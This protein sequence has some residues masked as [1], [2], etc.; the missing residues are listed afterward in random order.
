MKNCYKCKRLQ[1]NKNFYKHFKNK[2]GL[3]DLCLDC[4]K[5]YRKINKGLLQ[6]KAKEYYQ[7]NKEEILLKVQNYKKLYPKKKRN[8]QLKSIFGISLKKYNLLL[9]KQNNKCL[10]CKKQETVKDFRTSKI[11]NLAVDHNHQTGK[12]R[13]LLC[14]YC[15]TALGYFK[16]DINRLENAIKYLKQT[17]N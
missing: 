5:E 6:Q 2:D 14:Q 16:D 15:N 9:K 17:T 10:I 12:V 13:G 7:N 3:Q 8:S 11:K 1:S 4:T